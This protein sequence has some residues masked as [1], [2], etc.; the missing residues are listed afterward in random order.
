VRAQPAVIKF[1][2]G[3]VYLPVPEERYPWRLGYEE[4]L[5]L[6]TGRDGERTTWWT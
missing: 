2:M 3:E 4:E 5:L 6:W 1:S